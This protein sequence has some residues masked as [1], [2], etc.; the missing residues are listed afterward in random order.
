MPGIG[1]NTEHSLWSQGCH[2]WDDFLA[3]P[4]DYSIG[5]A[6]REDVIA[7]LTGCRDALATGHH[8]HFGSLLGARS[9][10]RA[11]PHFQGRA[12][13]LDIETDGGFN[14]D[15]IT[16]IGLYDG[17]EFICLTADEGFGALPDILSNYS[18]ILTFFGTSFDLPIIRKRFPEMDMDHLHWDLCPSFRDLGVRGG[19]KKIEEQFGLVRP[20]EA[21][22]L[23]GRDAIRLWRAYLRGSEDAL[24]TLIAY[25]REDVVNLWTLAGRCYEMLEDKAF[26]E[27][28]ITRGPRLG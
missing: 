27:A 7:C 3:S 23:N 2:T 25:N 12:V 4:E 9:C 6:C 16:M 5:G 21:Q 18:M 24:Q 19:L 13:C 26:T 1:G 15:A 11:W 22:G 28:G 10:W 17:K 20:D 14:G 8:Q